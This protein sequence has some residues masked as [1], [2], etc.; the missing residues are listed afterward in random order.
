[1]TKPSRA[2][3]GW[4]CGSAVRCGVKGNAGSPVAGHITSRATGNSSSPIARN[5]AHCSESGCA[6]NGYP[7]NRA[8]IQRIEQRQRL[9]GRHMA[10]GG[11]R[12]VNTT[13]FSR[14]VPSPIF[15]A[16]WERAS[17]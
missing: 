11:S 15:F 16:N 5:A 14:R 1:M 9:S 6:S 13:Y 3:R 10:N 8:T 12:M 17:A 4:C 7:I 2:E